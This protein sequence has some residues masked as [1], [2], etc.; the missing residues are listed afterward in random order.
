MALYQITNISNG[1]VVV[2][3]PASS[4][5]DIY[6]DIG[7]TKTTATLPSM[8][9]DILAKVSITVLPD[10]SAAI[11][12]D[13]GRSQ[14]KVVPVTTATVTVPADCSTYIVAPAGTIAALTLNLAATPTIR[15]VKLI[16]TQ[17]VTSLTMSAGG[18]NTGTGLL[19]SAS[20]NSYAE[21]EYLVAT[22]TWY[23]CG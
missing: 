17:V 5:D 16:F 1:P 4:T 13:T 19:T 8:S 3:N 20:A 14:V 10:S 23:R 18:S 15:R 22:T 6:L 9:N 12:V 11:A 21:Y 7:Q 2:N